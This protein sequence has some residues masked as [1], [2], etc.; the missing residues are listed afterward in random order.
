MGLF[1]GRRASL[2]T[3]S[4]FSSGRASEDDHGK[5]AVSSCC[6]QRKLSLAPTKV[7]DDESRQAMKV[8][9]A[10]RSSKHGCPSRLKQLMCLAKSVRLI[11]RKATVY[12][13]RG[14]VIAWESRST[15]EKQ[16]G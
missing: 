13:A 10:E 2:P 3:I 8:K 6:Q 4:S 9:D 7:T 11:K 14:D 16:Q 15:T 12:S 1:T 5:H